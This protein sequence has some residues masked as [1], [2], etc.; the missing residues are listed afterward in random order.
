MHFFTLL[1]FSLPIPGASCCGNKAAKAAA[2]G[3]KEAAP[4]LSNMFLRIASVVTSFIVGFSTGAFF[5][6][7]EM[8]KQHAADMSMMQQ[9]TPTTAASATTSVSPPT[10]AASV[11]PATVQP[12]VSSP[13]T[14]VS[15]P[16]TSVSSRGPP[17][18]S[19]KIIP[20]LPAVTRQDSN[21][22]HKH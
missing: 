13:S 4:A 1:A 14:S 7:S 19:T 12:T 21:K 11:S 22:G 16:S 6:H 17:P 9:H 10:T 15:S 3:A 18:P 8:H 20:N 2:D 5:M